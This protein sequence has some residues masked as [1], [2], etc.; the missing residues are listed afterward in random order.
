[1]L[2]TREEYTET[3]SLTDSW[4]SY[5][6]P[7]AVTKLRITITGIIFPSSVAEIKIN[8][9]ENPFVLN[10]ANNYEIDNHVV[11]KVSFKRIEGTDGDISII[12]LKKRKE[13]DN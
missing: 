13:G 10:L 6:F 2:F 12:G 4:N 3:I 11:S 9:S 1:M 8:D 5:T 7:K